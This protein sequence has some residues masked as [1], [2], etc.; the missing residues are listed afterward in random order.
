[1]I[2]SFFF[3]FHLQPVTLALGG[4][5]PIVIFEDF[6]DLDKAAEWTLFGCFWTNGQICSAPF[7]LILQ[8]SSTYIV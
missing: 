7:R 2:L 1:M 6:S 4:K 8:V 5:N 3:Y